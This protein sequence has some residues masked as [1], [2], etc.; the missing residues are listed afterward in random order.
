MP[1]GGFPSLF[2]IKS[3]LSPR[4]KKSFPQT[5]T[6]SP[7]PL[8]SS[9]TSLLALLKNQTHPSHLSSSGPLHLLF[10]LS[11]WPFLVFK[12]QVT[13]SERPS[14]TPLFEVARVIIFL[15][16]AFSS[17]GVANFHSTGPESK[18]FWDAA[19]H[20]HAISAETIPLCYCRQWLGSNKALFTKQLVD[21]FAP[22]LYCLYPASSVSSVMAGS[23]KPPGPGTV[24]LITC[25]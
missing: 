7:K 10:L 13:F 19:G 25:C 8:S 5:P 1:S 4:P 18:Y 3:S 9:H 16:P 23:C 22:W 14:Q 15:F 12:L 6:L 11:A 21:R 24:P 20:S 17:H 2:N